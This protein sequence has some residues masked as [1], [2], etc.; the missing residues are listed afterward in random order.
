MKPRYFDRSFKHLLQWLIAGQRGGGNRALIIKAIREEPRNANQLGSLLGVDYR[1]ARHHL[2]ILEKNGLVTTMGDRYGKTY[3]LS[4]EL[5][6]NYE[7]FE[8]ISNEIGK[9][10]KRKKEGVNW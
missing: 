1:T 8:E 3:F 2:N 6:E 9:K 7:V 4:N 10:L 5:E